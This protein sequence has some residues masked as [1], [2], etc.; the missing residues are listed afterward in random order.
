MTARDDPAHDAGIPGQPRLLLRAIELEPA[1]H[2]ATG[3][4]SALEIGRQ[5]A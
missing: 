2:F 4:E 1:N 5:R 3:I